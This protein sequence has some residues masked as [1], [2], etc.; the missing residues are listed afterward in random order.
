MGDGEVGVAFCN[1]DLQ[2]SSCLGGILAHVHVC[3]CANLK[4]RPIIC[5]KQSSTSLTGKSPL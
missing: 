4:I 5:F 1:L 3:L 2:E